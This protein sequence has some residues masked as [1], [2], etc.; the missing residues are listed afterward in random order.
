MKN[1]SSEEFLVIPAARSD[2]GAVA[3]VLADAFAA[4]EHTTGL[5]PTDNRSARLRRLFNVA[6]A[7]TFASGG[8]AWLAVDATDRSA[9]GAALWE[10]PGAHV[11]TWRT[12]INA[13][14]FLHIF[15]KRAFDAHRTDRSCEAHRPG[16]PHWYL[17]DI[18]TATA[19]RGRG[20][21]TALL[22][23]R[24]SVADEQRVGVYLESSSR[25]NVGYYSRFGFVERSVIPAYGTI[26]LT[27]MWRAPA[28]RT[29]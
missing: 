22:T 17:K 3:D 10:A 12:V 20:V 19:G 25:A 21:G 1:R 13:P 15:G 24:L 6:V 29:S 9:L 16:V 23:H 11:P 26:E 4:D 5:L 8:N 14:Q 18:G 27:G 7:D 28:A 2:S